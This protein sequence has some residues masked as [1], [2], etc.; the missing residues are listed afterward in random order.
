MF[1]YA[2]V[3]NELGLPPSVRDKTAT[4]HLFT[5]VEQLL[6]FH[7]GVEQFNQLL[8]QF[9]HL[10]QFRQSVDAAGCLPVHRTNLDPHFGYGFYHVLFTFRTTINNRQSQ[11]LVAI[12]VV[13]VPAKC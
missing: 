7:V 12:V 8:S 3:H 5:A 1:V 13:D 6:T 10:R 9:F 11:R 2:R 4:P